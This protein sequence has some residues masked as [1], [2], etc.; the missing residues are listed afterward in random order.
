MPGEKEGRASGC[1]IPR[2]RRF[3]KPGTKPLAGG[4][5]VTLAYFLKKV[6]EESKKRNRK[7]GERYIAPARTGKGRAW[8]TPSGTVRRFVGSF[9]TGWEIQNPRSPARVFRSG[10]SWFQKWP[11][12]AHRQARRL[13]GG[14]TLSRLGN[15]THQQAIWRGR[16]AC[17]GTVEDHRADGCLSA[18]ADQPLPPTFR[19]S[20]PP[21]VSL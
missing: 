9:D 10:N 12:D 1:L 11:K 8:G 19:S 3:L 2:R 18:G 16:A 7:L 20:S 5:Y 17:R 21:T 13:S 15:L 4:Y 14:Q 6:R